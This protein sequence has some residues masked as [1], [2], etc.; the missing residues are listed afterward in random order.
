MPIETHTPR[1]EDRSPAR[2]PAMPTT[3]DQTPD[4]DQPDDSTA[5]LADEFQ[6]GSL[7]GGDT[8]ATDVTLTTFDDGGEAGDEVQEQLARQRG[9]D[10]E[11]SAD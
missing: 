1:P 8:V 2:A 4:T 3:S 11:E 10:E 7:E 5:D 6:S 9:E